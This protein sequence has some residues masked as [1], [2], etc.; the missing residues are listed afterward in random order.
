MLLI[1]TVDRR[2]GRSDCAVFV[3]VGTFGADGFIRDAG[4]PPEGQRLDL[5][6][7][8]YAAM[9]VDG[10]PVVVGW[11]SSWAT[12][13]MLD[14]P[15]F[16]GGVIG[17][18]RRLSLTGGRVGQHVA[19]ADDAFLCPSPSPPIAGRGRATIDGQAGFSIS[20]K[21]AGAAVNIVADPEQGS[22]LVERTGLPQLRW[23]QHHSEVLT[24]QSVRDLALFVDG[25]AIELFIAPDAVAVSVALPSGHCPFEVRCTVG[26]TA[27][28]LA[29]CTR[30]P[31]SS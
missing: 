29:W 8:F 2:G 21:G 13:R 22:I 7:D 4:A 31:P 6:P 3:W 25:P 12:A 23:R 26:G 24:P 16:A 27:Q 10:A 19:I 20:I 9:A 14:W 15:G 11:L 30:M 17:L 5:G 28:P 1:S 18:P